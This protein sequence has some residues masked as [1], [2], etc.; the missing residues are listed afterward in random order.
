MVVFVTFGDTQ[1]PM[2]M[3]LL[4]KK[5]FDIGGFGLLAM[6]NAYVADIKHSKVTAWIPTFQ[7]TTGCALVAL[8]CLT[9]AILLEGASSDESRSGRI[10]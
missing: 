7:L 10:E 3:L 2:L 1:R 9:S 8:V 5:V 4:Q 6:F